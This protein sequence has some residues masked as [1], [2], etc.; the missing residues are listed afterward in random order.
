MPLILKWCFRAKAILANLKESR[1]VNVTYR[2][3]NA[4]DVETPLDIAPRTDSLD[5]LARKPG[6]LLVD[7]DSLWLMTLESYLRAM[8]AAVFV[9]TSPREA[10]ELFRQNA[11]EVHLVLLDIAMNDF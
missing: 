9:A 2:D 1:E 6:I 11:H 10:I 5:P 4:N 7:L 8:G 3:A